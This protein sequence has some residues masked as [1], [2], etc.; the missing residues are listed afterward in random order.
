M[1]YPASF[2]VTEKRVR[3]KGKKPT[4]PHNMAFPAMMSAL[5]GVLGLPQ[6]F[7]DIDAHGRIWESNLDYFFQMGISCEGFGLF[8]DLPHAVLQTGLFDGEPLVDCFSA[9]GIRY[10]LAADET[11]LKKDIPLD[12]EDLQEQVCRHLSRDLPL[13]LLYHGK[14]SGSLPPLYNNNQILLALGYENNAVRAYPFR[15]GHTANQAFQMMKN[16]KL[17][18]DWK[19]GLFGILFVDGLCEPAD[20]R[21]ISLKALQRGYEMMTASEANMTDYGFGDQLYRTWM[22]RIDDDDNYRYKKYAKRYI[23]PEEFDLAERRCY[24]AEFLTE[25]Q[26][27]LGQGCLQPAA[28]AFR[29]IP[30]A[31]W[32]VH[33]LV[34]HDVDSSR[35]TRD[36][37]LNIIRQCKDLE[38]QAAENIDDVLKRFN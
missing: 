4:C 32:E 31:M 1:A 28:E 25:A 38:N 30:D 35:F 34:F 19:D 24:T 29:A 36:K 18:P 13:V 7:G 33:R 15:D 22:Q 2:R 9:E 26:T 8:F 27:Y 17:Y 14:F 21:E 5:K 11:V 37:I 23:H 3:K 16:S 12:R 20:R 6:R 10:R